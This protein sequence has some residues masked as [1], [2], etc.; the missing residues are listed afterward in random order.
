MCE[1]SPFK[2]AECYQNFG[3]QADLQCHVYDQHR[4]QR[5]HR[6]AAP[7][8]PE[9]CRHDVKLEDATASDGGDEASR[10]RPV[11]AIKAEGERDDGEGL[12][13]AVNVKTERRDGDGDEEEELIDVGVNNRADDAKP[14]S[15]D[16]R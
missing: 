10:D 11:A 3:S 7:A 6:D 15:P 1:K 5:T 16:A 9:R 2:C 14:S 8:S 4:A 12:D 13:G